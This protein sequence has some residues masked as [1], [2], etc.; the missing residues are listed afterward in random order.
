MSM[1]NVME[2]SSIMPSTL[3]Y[4]SVLFLTLSDNKKKKR[5][6]LF[7]NKIWIF[8]GETISS[9]VTEGKET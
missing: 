4:D 6:L 9:T 3:H 2:P 8:D 5:E 7:F 1:V